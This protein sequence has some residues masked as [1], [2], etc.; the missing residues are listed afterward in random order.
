MA[1]QES[2][3]AGSGAGER[4]ELASDSGFSYQMSISQPAGILTI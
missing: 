1:V 4:S 3:L 2:G